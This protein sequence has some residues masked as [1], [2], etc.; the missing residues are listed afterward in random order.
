[1][2]ITHPTAA[3]FSFAAAGLFANLPDPGSPAA[4]GWLIA[5]IAAIAV[6]ANQILG[7]VL[8]VKKLKGNDPDIANTYTT[9]SE[10][11]ELVKQVDV[12][13]TEVRGISRSLSTEFSAINRALGRIEGQLAHIS[14]NTHPPGE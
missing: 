10:H 8:N 12:L 6:S 5:V 7:A 11:G 1:M 4:M 2:D 9:K 14:K 3:V 13:K